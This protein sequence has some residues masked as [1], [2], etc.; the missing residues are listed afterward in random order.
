MKLLLALMLAAAMA[1]GSAVQTAT[2][3]PQP[4]NGE[5]VAVMET[6]QGRIVLMFFPD[7][8]P[9]HVE[10][11][12][13]LAAA[14]FYDGIKFHRVIPKFMIQ[15]GDP[16]TK[17]G[18]KSTWGTGGSSETVRA[19]FNDVKHVRGILSMAR[20]ND[21]DSASSQFFIMVADAPHLDGKYSAFGK[22]VSGMDAVDKIVALPRDEKDCPLE[23]P[24]IK[25]VRIVKWPIK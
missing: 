2:Q 15:G 19:E 7:K 25:S 9:K 5:D 22:V 3:D 1:G 13:K 14:K 18:E 10:N 11:F 17:N 20:T 8:A 16:N 4:K 6:S 21:P 24:V 23:P 12:K